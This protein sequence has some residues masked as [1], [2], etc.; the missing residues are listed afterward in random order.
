VPGGGDERERILRAAVRLSAADGPSDLTITQIRRAAGVSRRN[1]DRYFA[2]APECV[3][4]SVEWL[5]GRA[6]TRAR[7]WANRDPDPAGRT[8]RL[9]LALCTQVSTNKPLARL[10]FGGLLE[11]GRDGL[12]CRERILATGAA[13]MRENPSLSGSAES[14]AAEASAAAAWRVAEVEV[15]GGRAAGLPGLATLIDHILLAPADS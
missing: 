12:L 11:I 14:I 10:A 7:V 3:L 8:F 15:I 9:V 2:S 1:F 5:V 4:A 13:R 6:S